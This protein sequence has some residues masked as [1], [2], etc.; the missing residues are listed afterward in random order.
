MPIY[1]NYI[2]KKSLFKIPLIGYL[3]KQIG[4]IPIDRANRDSAIHS[5]DDAAKLIKTQKKNISI[6]PEGTRRRRDSITDPHVS[7]FK[8][9]IYYISYIKFYLFIFYFIFLYIRSFSS[10]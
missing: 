3:L 2:A 5:L 10:C 9:G 4:T 6:S 1:L 7:D 8:K